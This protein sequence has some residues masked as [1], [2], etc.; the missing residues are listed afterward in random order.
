MISNF[1]HFLGVF[2]PKCSPIVHPNI[3][4]KFDIMATTIKYEIRKE[5]PRPDGSFPIRIRITHNRKN[6]YLPT[7]WTILPSQIDKEGCITD[8]RIDGYVYDMIRDIRTKI[9]ELGIRANDMS[10]E[11]IIDYINTE[12]E[13]KRPFALDFVQYTRD[14]IQK[15]KDTGHSGTAVNYNCAINSLVKFA[16]RETVDVLA[17]TSKFVQNWIDWIGEQ[18]TPK[19]KS[20]GRAA[21][22]Y[23]A[24]L[25]AMYHRARKEFNDEERGIIRIPFSPFSKVDVPKPKPTRKRALTMEQLRAIASVERP[26]TWDNKRFNLSC[27][28]FML[29]FMLIG[30]NAADLYDAPASALDG[31]RITYKR[32]KTRTRRDDEAEI[33]VKVEPEVIHLV[34]KY[35]DPKGE[36]LFRF[37]RLYSDPGTFNAA[38]NK[39]LKQVGK[40]LGIEDLEF[41]AARHSWATIATNEAGIDKYTVHE[42]LNHVDPAMNVTDIYIKKTWSNIDKA[43]RAVLDL[44]FGKK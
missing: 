37:C 36:R 11:D 44:V 22:L 8:Y 24:C 16:K 39:G 21:S 2:M 38:L 31:E 13:K 23:F 12:E 40:A 14:Y 41:Y 29:S 43:N 6:K 10:V 32:K 35:R 25:R 34:E 28:A 1:P 33:S 20:G 27:D 4:S 17:M 19:G 26:D 3:V 7:P 9:D 42:A 5:R 15:L 30:M 18:P